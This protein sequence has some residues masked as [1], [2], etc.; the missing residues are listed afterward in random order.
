MSRKKLGLLGLAAALVLVAFALLK[1]STRQLPAVVASAETHAPPR[2]GAPAGGTQPAAAIAPPPPGMRSEAPLQRPDGGVAG[3]ALANDRALF[4]SLVSLGNGLHLG[5]AL[6]KNAANAD[7]LVDKYCEENRQLHTPAPPA[8]QD[9]P[10][11]DAA[12]FMA[13]L[14]D[15]QQPFDDPPGRLRLP[16]ELRER[17]L[18]YGSDWPSRVSDEDLAGLDFSWMAALAQ[19]DHWSLLGAGRL[20][21]LP[22]ANAGEQPMPNYLPMQEWSKLRFGLARRRGDLPAAG[23]EVHHLGELLR[24][25]GNLIAQMIAVALLGMEAHARRMGSLAGYDVTGWPAP[26]LDQKDLERRMAMGG[27]YFAYPGV[28]PETLKKAMACLGTP[29]PALLEALGA[30]KAF[31]SFSGGDNLQLIKELAASRGCET[32]VI[33]RALEANEL[34]APD[35]LRSLGADLE[36][37]LPRYVTPAP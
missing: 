11:R 31:G 28:K 18:S 24:T 2:A 19:F 3:P 10:E 20:R 26:D 15:Y 16:A 34:S 17:L 29:C 7:R 37:Q 14:M 1:N 21:E 6:A 27:M 9:S 4:T 5:E 13:P 35:A 36:A 22:A 33:T 23:A 8:N 12:A 25:Q 32:R 30:N